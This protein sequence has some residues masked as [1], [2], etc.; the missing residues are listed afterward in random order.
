[1]KTILELLISEI[2]KTYL[3]KK[4]PNQKHII[5]YIYNF[6]HILHFI[7]IFAIVLII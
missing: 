3:I 5:N 7:K 6:I 4:F 2:L 1:M